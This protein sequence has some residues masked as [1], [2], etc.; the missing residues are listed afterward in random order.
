MI[1]K[2]IKQRVIAGRKIIDEYREAHYRLHSKGWYRGISED[3]TSLLEKLVYDLEKLGFTSNKSE[4]EAKKTEIL[5][6]F[7]NTS[8]L[9][10]IQELGFIDWEDFRKN[11]TKSNSEMLRLK[12]C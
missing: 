11:V 4:F 5:S 6:K 8:D 3:H 9:L 12:W 1:N 10:N 2:E 7:W